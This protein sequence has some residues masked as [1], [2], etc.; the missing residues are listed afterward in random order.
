MKGFLIVAGILVGLGVFLITSYSRIGDW[1]IQD[2]VTQEGSLDAMKDEV[3]KDENAF[4]TRCRPFLERR[5]Q[6]GQAARILDED[7]F[8]ALAHDT[9]TRYQ[10][11]P[12]E[13]DEDYGMFELNAAVILD[14][15][16]RSQ[17][18]FDL[19]KRYSISF[20]NSKRAAE[21]RAAMNRISLKYGYQ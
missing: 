11:T 5:A 17:E 19:F 6:V 18:A 7:Y 10:D 13:T 3:A 8:L 20:P 14:Q 1:I 16:V 21:V 2:V 4:A 15:R 9:L 12:L